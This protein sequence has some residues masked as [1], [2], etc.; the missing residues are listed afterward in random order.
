MN[1]S[2]YFDPMNAARIFEL[3]QI[4]FKFEDLSLIG[5][6]QTSPDCALALYKN[7]RRFYVLYQEDYVSSLEYVKKSI[8]TIYHVDVKSFLPVKIRDDKSGSDDEFNLHSKI[9]EGNRNLIA[10]VTPRKDSLNEFLLTVY[11][12]ETK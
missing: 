2:S 5:Y 4:D 8:D 3:F 11:S 7:K 6:E 9:Y 12:P 10:E 1:C